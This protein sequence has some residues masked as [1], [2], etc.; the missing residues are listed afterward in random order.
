MEIYQLQQ[1]Q[2]YDYFFKKSNSIMFVVQEDTFRI[3]DANEAACSFYGYSYKEML[4]LQ[5]DD[6]DMEKKEN[7]IDLFQNNIDFITRHK[8]SVN[9]VVEVK[10]KTDIIQISGSR[11]YNL[12]V[13]DISSRKYT[14]THLI[15]HNSELEIVLDNL[16]FMAWYKNVHGRYTIANRH[17]E[18]YCGH[19][20]D[21][22]IGY[23]DYDIFPKQLAEKYT[24]SDNEVLFGQKGAYIEEIESEGRWREEYKC[25]VYNKEGAVIG[26]VGFNRDITSRKTKDNAIKEAI[27][28]E[29]QLLRETIEFK[30]NFITLITHEFKTPIAIINAALQTMEAVCE[31]E[32]SEKAIKYLDKIKQ[33]SD[34]QQ[35]LVENLL[36]ITRLKAGRLKMNYKNIDI[37]GLTRE[38]IESV[39]AFSQRKGIRIYF[40]TMIEELWVITDNE[41]YE[42][43]LLNLLSNAI[44]YTP[45]NKS[46]FVKL[47]LEGFFIKLEVKDRGIGIAS[48][49]QDL[50]FGK[51]EQINNSLSRQAEGTGI[52]LYLVKSFAEAL[53]GT[54]SLI[55]KEN[56]GS[57]FT[58]MLPIQEEET[59]KQRVHKDAIKQTVNMELSDI[60]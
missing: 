6:I 20:K 7:I 2:S 11:Y 14:L 29:E 1:E 8:T 37:V 26:T 27:R 23:T 42:R 54:V 13:T 53:G 25:P 52:G 19:G 58:V 43:I 21:E 44:K 31:N 45:S 32:L 10:V 12:I 50:I 34:R 18:D 48:D 9:S 40:K 5:L 17:L 49:K 38:I 55:S 47:S 60:L 41:K 59:P 24:K 15:N 35:R 36:D 57:T 22:I 46:I 39:K 3:I 30:D 4:Q 33:N 16:P 56:K 28:K 51:F